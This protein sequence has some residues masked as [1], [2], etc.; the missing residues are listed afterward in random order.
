MAR[1]AR[2]ESERQTLK[3]LKGVRV[4][5]A[6]MHPEAE[7]RLTRAVIQTDVE[8][9]LRL[10]G[11]PIDAASWPYLFVRVGIVPDIHGY[12][13][14][15]I[16]VELHQGVLLQRDESIIVDASTWSVGTIAGVRKVDFRNY[17]R[18][19]I[20]DKVDQFI[21]AYLSVNPK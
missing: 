2:N 4:V 1:A 13:P 21:N 9:Q 6:D 14:V 16:D 19:S 7:P 8:Q 15:D 17:V 3:G 20:K 10:A 5:V 11:I 12:W 18:D